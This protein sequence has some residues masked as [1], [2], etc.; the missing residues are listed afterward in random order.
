MIQ[1][2]VCTYDTRKE[3][4]PPPT[5]CNTLAL[6]Q[7]DAKTFRVEL[8]RNQVKKGAKVLKWRASAFQAAGAALDPLGSA[9]KPFAWKL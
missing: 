7:V 9:K 2:N 4:L 3:E 1:S 5:K 6:T 8:K